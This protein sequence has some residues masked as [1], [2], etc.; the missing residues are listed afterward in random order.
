M[1][2]PVTHHQENKAGLLGRFYRAAKGFS[3][4]LLSRLISRLIGRGLAIKQEREHGRQTIK[5]NLIELVTAVGGTIQDPDLK[6][7]YFLHRNQLRRRHLHV[8]P[9]SG[10]PVL[11]TE[12]L[13]ERLD[14]HRRAV[15]SAL[16]IFA[17]TSRSAVEGLA[18]LFEGRFWFYAHD[19]LNQRLQTIFTVTEIREHM[20]VPGYVPG[21]HTA[22]DDFG[23]R[24]FKQRFNDH[25]TTQAGHFLT[26]LRLALDPAVV[27]QVVETPLGPAGS[28]RDQISAGDPR[29]A[30]MS[31]TELA[32]YLSIGHEKFPDPFGLHSALKAGSL[33]PRRI[34]I[35]QF[36][37]A[38]DADYGHFQ[39]ALAVLDKQTH[40]DFDSIEELLQ[41]IGIQDE[42]RRWG[43]LWHKGNSM[44][45]LRLT[46][47]AFDMARRIQ[48]GRIQTRI[49]AGDYIR[50]N[51]QA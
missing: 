28:I 22:R 4:F 32:V 42:R 48:T 46:I 9:G 38:T 35:E 6:L 10:V 47:A 33:D 50:Q 43:V 20:G 49:E 16:L 5:A 51:L 19:S 15:F 45:D 29:A 41:Q 24:G 34:F 18:Y 2:N 14:K 25:S 30:S 8:R 17:A 21:L 7:E 44:A 13:D 11:G 27:N 36:R 40:P 26:G 23:S 1:Q 12:E 31:D 39:Q 37:R 3:L